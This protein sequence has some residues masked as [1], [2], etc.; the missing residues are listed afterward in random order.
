MAA[1]III[2]IYIVNEFSFDSFFD[3][4]ENIY[5]ISMEGEISG[6]FFDVAVTPGALAWTAVD[7][8]PEIVTT[9]RIVPDGSNALITYNDKNLYENKTYYVDSTFFEV[10]DFKLLEGDPATALNEPRSI[11]LTKPLA[12]KIF[13]MEEA[14]GKTIQINNGDNIKVTGILDDLPTHTHLDFNMLCSMSTL[15]NIFNQWGA[16]SLYTYIRVVPGTDPQK[17]EEKFPDFLVKNMDFLSES[18]QFTAHL[19]RV[20]DL[21][22]HSHKMV[23]ITP[24]SDF[25]YI[26]LFGAIAVFILIIACINFMNLTTAKSVKRAREVGLRKVVGA[27]RGLLIGQ[28]IGESIILSLFAMIIALLMVELALPVFN[29]LTGQEL[30]FSILSAW[31]I[32]IVLIGL[33]IFVGLLAGSYPAFYLSSFQPIKVLKGDLF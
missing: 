16:L 4:H 8:F 11:I 31:Q 13:G 19:Q 1:C 25:S 29:E 32:P 6:D 21:H 26:I 3:K 17:L 28:F 5:R 33:I 9:T 18:I 7:N 14:L 22:L 20:S 27:N 23:E 2:L 12:E 10:F 24:N 15:G 30:T